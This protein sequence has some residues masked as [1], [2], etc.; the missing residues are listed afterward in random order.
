M[1]KRS[2][3]ENIP[4]YCCYVKEVYSR[5][6]HHNCRAKPQ[7][8]MAKRMYEPIAYDP[9]NV[10]W[11]PE[12]A[13]PLQDV[14]AELFRHIDISPAL[15]QQD[16]VVIQRL[17]EFDFSSFDTIFKE[18]VFVS[19]WHQ[20]FKTYFTRVSKF[21]IFF[22]LQKGGKFTEYREKWKC[23]FQE[24]YQEFVP[25][26]SGHRTWL[27]IAGVTATESTKD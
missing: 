26:I 14:A 18:L 7:I 17:K 23:L 2:I 6:Y 10:V 19:I 22:V 24:K 8:R 16:D 15:L 4:C 27:Q 5:K 20:Q 21:L 11:N 9:T 12:A 3:H 25:L 1:L 13:N